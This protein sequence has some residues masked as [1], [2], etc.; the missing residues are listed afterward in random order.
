M[1]LSLRYSFCHTVLV[2]P[3]CYFKA[4]LSIVFFFFPCLF[5]RNL[6][7]PGMQMMLYMNSMEKNCVVKG[8]NFSFGT[9]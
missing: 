1:A 7:I 6:R 4:M 9:G 8:E 2:I 5:F 3:M